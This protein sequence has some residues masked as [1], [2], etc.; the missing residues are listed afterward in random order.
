MVEHEKSLK[1]K[2]S[3]HKPGKLCIGGGKAGLYGAKS[4]GR[5]ELD[6]KPSPSDGDQR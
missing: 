4:G 6:G 2:L 3:S 5:S 1:Q